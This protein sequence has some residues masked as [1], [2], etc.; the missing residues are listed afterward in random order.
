MFEARNG[1]SAHLLSA[2]EVSIF[3]TA[4]VAAPALWLVFLITALLGFKFQWMILVVIGLTLSTSNLVSS[5]AAYSLFC[6]FACSRSET[7]Q[8]LHSVS[9]R[10]S[11]ALF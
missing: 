10:V 11:I 3:W 9:S 2:A 5:V 7:R 6:V 8:W 1:D 4:L